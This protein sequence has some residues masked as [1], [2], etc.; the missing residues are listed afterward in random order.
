MTDRMVP[1]DVPLDVATWDLSHWDHHVTEHHGRRCIRFGDANMALAL[2]DVVVGDGLIE[3]DLAVTRERSFHGVIWRVCDGDNHESFF[4]RPHQVGNPDAI[5]YTPVSNGISSWQLYHGPGFWAPVA[6]P[7]DGWFAIRV[8]FAG[9]RAEVY[10]VDLGSPALHIAELKWPSEPGG[11]GLQVGGPGLHV[12]RFAFAMGRPALREPVAT[13]DAPRPGVIRDWSVSDPFPET[14][15]SGVTHLPRD[16]VAARAWS[17]LKGRA[18]RA[19][20]SLPDPRSP[21]RAEHRARAD[22]RPRSTIRRRAARDR[23]Q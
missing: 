19:A 3:V 10:V 22:D 16:L 13:D 4:V 1:K 7:I 14:E 5:Q 18:V 15:V 11:I 21:R 23:F 2:A 8:A 9:S 20:R 12:A 17:E 6:F